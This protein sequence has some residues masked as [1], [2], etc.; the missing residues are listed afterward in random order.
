MAEEMDKLL[1]VRYS[2]LFR[3]YGVGEIGP[4]IQT[5]YQIVN[6]MEQHP[7]LLRP[8]AAHFLIVSLD[9]MIIRPYVGT[10]FDPDGKVLPLFHYD[11]FAQLEEDVGR[12]T[13]IILDTLSTKQLPASSHDVMQAIEENWGEIKKVFLWA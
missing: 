11:S 12:V 5:K 8:D 9:Q 1:A 7:D 13:S 6:R 10:I 2:E 4:L 3:T